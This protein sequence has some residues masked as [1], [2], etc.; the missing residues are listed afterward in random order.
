M[1]L[2]AY[3]RERESQATKR[4]WLR[5]QRENRDKAAEEEAEAAA[6]EEEEVYDRVSEAA[7]MGYVRIRARV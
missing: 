2:E 1:V 6:A 5:E 4:P 7:A 3:I